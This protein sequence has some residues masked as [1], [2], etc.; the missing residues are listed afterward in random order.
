MVAPNLSP[1]TNSTIYLQRSGWIVL[2]LALAAVAAAGF[3]PKTTQEKSFAAKGMLGSSSSIRYE[4]DDETAES[5]D[6]LKRVVYKAFNKENQALTVR[7]WAEL[8][9]SDPSMADSLFEI[10]KDS[11]YGGYFFETKGVTPQNAN[12]KG[13]EFVLVESTRLQKF[14][15]SRPDPGAFA[16]YYGCKTAAGC[17]FPNLGGDAML[18]AP[19]PDDGPK[20]NSYSHLAFYVRNAPKER[21]LE[22]LNLAAKEYLKILASD[23]TS[24]VWF[25]TS[26]MGVP[27]LH[28]RLDSYPKYYTFSKFANEK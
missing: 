10:L 15:E 25:S 22:L 2:I 8:V 23:Q 20:G 4:I 1:K 19:R 9:A 7:Q 12:Q 26:G 18:I 16:D 17:V 21:V 5:Q 3:D 13:F 28:F 11:E 14:A 24:A 27:W 6:P